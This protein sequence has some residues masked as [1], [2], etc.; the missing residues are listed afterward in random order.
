M[1]SGLADK[2]TRSSRKKKK[3]RKNLHANRRFLISLLG[4]Y[5]VM[6]CEISFGMRVKCAGT[7]SMAGVD[8]L[9]RIRGQGGQGC[10]SSTELMGLRI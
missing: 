8:H 4:K 1:L 6:Y 9:V 5:D 10:P 2:K 3:S 7:A